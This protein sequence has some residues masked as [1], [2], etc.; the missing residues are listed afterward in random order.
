MEDLTKEERQKS[1]E[2]L[3]ALFEETCRELERGDVRWKGSMPDLLE[4]LHVAWY[5]GRPLD[6][7]LQPLTFG[8]MSADMCRRLHVRAPLNPYATVGRV[9]ERKDQTTTL[10]SRL[11]R[12]WHEGRE[13]EAPA[14]MLAGVGSFKQSN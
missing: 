11:L 2:L 3:A 1:R 10:A 7:N 12:L 13:A 9:R 8:R 6:E 14:R 4:M 5:Y